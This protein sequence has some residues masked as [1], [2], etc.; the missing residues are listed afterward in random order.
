MCR[1]ESNR[2]TPEETGRILK[3]LRDLL[4]ESVKLASSTGP[5]GITRG[6]Q[7]VRALVSL[8][9]EYLTAGKLDEPPV[10]LRKLFERLGATYIKLGQFIAS[11]PS[12]FPQEYVLEFQKCLDQTEPVPFSR[13]KK[14]IEEEL[15]VPI[16]QVRKLLA[17]GLHRV[18]LALLMWQCQ[19]T[20]HAVS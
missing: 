20:R 2:Y 3:E 4:E 9:Q 10:I 19:R 15:S 11:S 16:D 7:A 13:I 12:L 14:T 5:R 17:C 8:T 1:P 6:V 18:A